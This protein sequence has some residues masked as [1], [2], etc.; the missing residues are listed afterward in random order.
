[1]AFSTDGQFLFSSSDDGTV[2]R[3]TLE[4]ASAP[5]MVLVGQNSSL[6]RGFALHGS[7]LAAGSSDGA[8]RLWSLDAEGMAGA[9]CTRVN[10][11]LDPREWEQY[12][13]REVAYRE[14]CPGLP[15]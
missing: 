5:E 12:V 13:S 10:R 2:R 15:V 14:T 8:V 7:T 1:L 3:W 9:V 11:N 4:G 6:V